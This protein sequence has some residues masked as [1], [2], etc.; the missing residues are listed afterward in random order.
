MIQEGIIPNQTASRSS[1][2]TGGNSVLDNG[3]ILSGTI[4]YVNTKQKSPTSGAS[5]FNDYFG[6]GGGSIYSRLIY[7]PRNFDLNNLP[8]ENPAD[9]SNIFYRALDNPIWIANNN[10]Y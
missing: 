6:G 8:C 5:A 9:G 4:N 10:F 2:Y 1:L 7:L 3:I